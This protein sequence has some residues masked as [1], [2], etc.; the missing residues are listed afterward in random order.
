MEDPF[1]DLKN[2]WDSIQEFSKKS[3][4]R[5][6]T[7]ENVDAFMDDLGRTKETEDDSKKIESEY[8]FK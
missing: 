4:I 6:D 8:S 2:L 1:E 5:L 7:S 3:G